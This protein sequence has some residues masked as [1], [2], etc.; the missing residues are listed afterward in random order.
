MICGDMR[1]VVAIK[2]DHP[3]V[4]TCL[5]VGSGSSSK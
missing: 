4:K 1:V 2:V 5:Q 3:S